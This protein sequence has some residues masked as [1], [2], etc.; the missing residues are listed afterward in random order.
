MPIFKQI[1]EGPDHEMMSVGILDLDCLEE[2]WRQQRLQASIRNYRG[3]SHGLDSIHVDCVLFVSFSG[4][5]GPS[6]LIGRYP[7]DELVLTDLTAWPAYREGTAC[8]DTWGRIHI[9]VSLGPGRF[10]QGRARTPVAAR[11][12]GMGGTVVQS[13]GLLRYPTFGLSLD[14]W[15]CT[16]ARGAAFRSHPRPLGHDLGCSQEAQPTRGDQRGNRKGLVGRFGIC[17]R[18]EALDCGKSRSFSSELHGV[19]LSL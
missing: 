16:V 2:K 10:R 11:V 15:G 3:S 14:N 19:Q 17:R 18:T 8:S 12:A 9:S 4:M 1:R 6:S 7:F 5:A 13:P